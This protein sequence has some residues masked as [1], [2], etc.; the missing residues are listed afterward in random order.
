[1]L[2][3]RKIATGRWG[4][5]ND[6]NGDESGLGRMGGVDLTALLTPE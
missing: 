5:E 4:P 2:G 1:M 6:L 3:D